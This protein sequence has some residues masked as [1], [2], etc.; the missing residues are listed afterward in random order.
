[1]AILE[2]V[3]NKSVQGVGVRGDIKRVKPGYFR[4]FLQPRGLAMPAT[5]SL[6]KLWKERRSK[7][8]VEKAELKNRAE[9]L[10]TILEAK[11]FTIS[12]K[13][14][15]KGTLYS[16]I[17]EDDIANMIAEQTDVTLD[18]TLMKLGTQVKKI[19]EVKLPVLLGEGV[20]VTLTV[21]VTAAE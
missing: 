9:E 19:G 8:E 11:E 1:M 16:A 12:A 5:D 20:E 21:D 3:L 14:T 17:H 18:P 4:N 10:K 6:R 13:A 15:D 2:V 7:L